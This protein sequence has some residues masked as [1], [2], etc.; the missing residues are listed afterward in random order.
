MS[1]EVVA[2]VDQ[3]AGFLS[4]FLSFFLTAGIIYLLVLVDLDGAWQDT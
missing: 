2:L 4:F 3:A 1:K